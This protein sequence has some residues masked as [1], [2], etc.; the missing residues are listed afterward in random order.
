MKKTLTAAFC[1]LIFTMGCNKSKS[2]N[3]GIIKEE[4]AKQSYTYKALDGT[5]A[6]VTFTNSGKK[7]TISIEANGQKYQLD[8]TDST[9]YERNSVKAEVKGD[10]LFIMQEDHVIPLVKDL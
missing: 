6:K 4:T 1:A 5:P 3:K 9:T 10:S 7:K 2:G 8:Q